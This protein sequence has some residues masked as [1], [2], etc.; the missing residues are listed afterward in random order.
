MGGIGEGVGGVEGG[1]GGVDGGMS[2]GGVVAGRW[3]R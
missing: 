3:W 1:V 2:V